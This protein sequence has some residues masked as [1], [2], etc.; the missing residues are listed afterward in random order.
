MQVP[1][2]LSETAQLQSG[3]GRRNWPFS[4][5]MITPW[6]YVYMSHPERVTPSVTPLTIDILIQV[7][8]Q[9]SKPVKSQTTLAA[10]EAKFPNTCR[11]KMGVSKGMYGSH[12]PDWL[13]CLKKIC[14]ACVGSWGRAWSPS[15]EILSLYC[16]PFL[17]VQVLGSRLQ[18]LLCRMKWNIVLLIKEKNNS[19]NSKI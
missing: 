11:A 15:R 9:C 6:G 19:H 18:L 2:H 16:F 14:L 7:K 8:C 1:L 5:N 13:L 4:S 10:V 17:R 3:Q 12:V